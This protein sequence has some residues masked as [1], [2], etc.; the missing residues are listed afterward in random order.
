MKTALI[1]GASDG[2]GLELARILAR[3]GHR[4]ILVARRLDRLHKLREELQLIG[5]IEVHCMGLDLSV[6]DAAADLYQQIQLLGWTVDFLINNAGVGVYGAFA[7]SDW[8]KTAAMIDLNIRSL[9]QLTHLFLPAMIAQ[10]SGRIMNVASTAAFQPG[11]GM[12]VYFATK[13]F[14]L[15]FSEALHHENCRKGVR[16]TALCPGPTRSGFAEAMVAP[17][18]SIPGFLKKKGLPDSASVARYAYRAMMRGDAVAVHGIMNRIM[19]A[20]IGL[21]P[22][23][24]VTRIAASFTGLR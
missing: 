16:V 18:Q 12:S 1:T 20:S 9:T 14:V 8:G 3:N 19:A 15:H 7:E 11:P 10:G 23:S 21:F 24:W 5:P 4:L 2:I 22:R 6:H 13:A 17:G